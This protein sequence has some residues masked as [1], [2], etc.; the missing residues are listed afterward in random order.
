MLGRGGIADA[1]REIRSAQAAAE[2]RPWAP[3][4]LSTAI[5]ADCLLLQGRLAE[6]RD[7]VEDAEPGE[8]A[9]LVTHLESKGRVRVAS[10]DVALGLMDLL[11]A[12]DEAE[13]LGSGT[14]P[15]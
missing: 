1:E 2:S 15:T 12:G 10:G 9:A 6:A 5:L 8:G 13:R 7:L 4:S 11:A 14:R 3:R